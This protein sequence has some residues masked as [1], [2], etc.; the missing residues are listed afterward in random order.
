MVGNVGDM[1]DLLASI[2]FPKE[3]IVN[4]TA[5][6]FAAY[7]EERKKRIRCDADAK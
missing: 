6:R 4:L 2:D 1:M 5:E 7:I 3:L